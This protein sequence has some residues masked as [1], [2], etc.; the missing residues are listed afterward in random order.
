MVDGR[1]GDPV[2]ASH[3]ACG[4][5]MAGYDT[6]LLAWLA[7]A[8]QFSANAAAE[9]SCR[10]TSLLQ[11]RR[12]HSDDDRHVLPHVP[13]TWRRNCH[14]HLLAAARGG[15]CLMAVSVVRK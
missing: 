12:V 2:L 8:S 5:A 15:S 11:R 1:P 10:N 7:G 4:F 3:R 9:V 6:S 14:M 13:T